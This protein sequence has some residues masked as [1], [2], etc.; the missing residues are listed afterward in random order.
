MKALKELIGDFVIRPRGS[1]RDYMFYSYDLK[2]VRDGGL[3]VRRLINRNPSS[4]K[5]E[6]PTLDWN[7]QAFKKQG[8]PNHLQ[9]AHH[10]P[11]CN[12]AREDLR[13]GGFDAKEEVIFPINDLALWRECL[14]KQGLG[15]K[16]KAWYRN[17]ILFDFVELTTGTII[18]IDGTSYHDKAIDSAR[19]DYVQRTLGRKTLRFPG[20]GSGG[21]KGRIKSRGL[22]Y[23]ALSEQSDPSYRLWKEIRKANVEA[24]TE[25]YLKEKERNTHAIPVLL[26]LRDNQ[27]LVEKELIMRES[28]LRRICSFHD[29]PYSLV[30]AEDLRD[31]AKDLY[32]VEITVIQKA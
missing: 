27:Y 20:Y 8:Q 16:D 12:R 3:Y 9:Q 25:F 24:A 6:L 18:E 30:L 11:I 22:L 7:R 32:R 2:K 4:T 13:D 21:P 14:G 15:E 19:D 26:Y 23:G 1:N 17:Y 29:I 5:L 10:S 28:V 31:I